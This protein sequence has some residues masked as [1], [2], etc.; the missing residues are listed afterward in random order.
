MPAHEL[1]PSTR[2]AWAISIA[3]ALSYFVVALFLLDDY[4]PTIDCVQGEYPYGERILEYVLTGNE[5][6]LVLRAKEPRPA[7]REPH[8]DFAM[9]RFPWYWVPPFVATLSAATCR[10]FWTELGILPPFSAHH[11]VRCTDS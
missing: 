5:E 2:R 9:Q 1:A 7:L 3:L 8:P 4:G 6:Y 11:L 10:V